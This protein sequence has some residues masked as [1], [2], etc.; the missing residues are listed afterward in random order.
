MAKFKRR[1]K[2]IEAEQYHNV[3]HGWPKGVCAA[4]DGVGLSVGPHVHTMY[5]SQ[6]VELE[7]GDWIVPEPDGAHYYPIK[8]EVFR[9]TYEPVED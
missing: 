5:N 3:P 8:D 1:P 6:I 7:D 2:V 4:C 9:G